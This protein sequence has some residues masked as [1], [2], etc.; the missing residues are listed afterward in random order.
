VTRRPGAR[1]IATNGELPFVRCYKERRR[2]ANHD[3]GGKPARNREQQSE[4]WS[5]HGLHVGLT[6]KCYHKLTRDLLVSLEENINDPI[7]LA[8]TVG[9]HIEGW[10]GLVFSTYK[11][12][13]TCQHCH[14][15]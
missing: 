1:G 7:I 2:N 4:M 12:P 5:Y 15:C 6:L 8:R 10:H 3:E 14:L 11:A 13:W 9:R